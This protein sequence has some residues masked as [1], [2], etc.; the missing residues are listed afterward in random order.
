MAKPMSEP[1]YY[2]EPMTDQDPRESDDSDKDDSRYE[3]FL[4][5]K[6]SFP[7]GLEVGSTHKVKV[8]RILD[9]EIQ[10][11]CSGKGKDEEPAQQD[12]S[13]DMYD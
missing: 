10:L 2:D 3:S 8:E 1:D 5:P 13:D 12:E 7:S 4:A 9:D 11:I 6:A